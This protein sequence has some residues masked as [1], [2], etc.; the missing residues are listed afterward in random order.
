M[1]VNTYIKR[2]VKQINLKNWI[3]R[4]FERVIQALGNRAGGSTVWNVLG[5][6]IR[7]LVSQLHLI[8]SE[9]SIALPA[10]NDWLIYQL[11]TF[12]PSRKIPVLTTILGV[13]HTRHGSTHH[14]EMMEEFFTYKNFVEVE[15][16]DVVVDVGAYVGGFT[17]FAAS[18]A[19]HVIAIEPSSVLYD[20]LRYNTE[21]FDNVSIL[22]KA[23]WKGKERLELQCSLSPDENSIFQPDRG[24]SGVKIEVEA[25]TVSNLVKDSG[26]E[27]IDFLKLEAEGAEPEILEGA[28]AD[29]LVP[30]KIAVDVNPE[31]ED[32]AVDNVIINLLEEHDFTWKRKSEAR[33]WGD[34]YI[35]AKSPEEL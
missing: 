16:G 14:V 33:Y 12:R 24:A 10:G 4:Q 2:E 23:A 5:H 19:R 7:I 1:I 17:I 22:E 13:S 34:Q 18:K 6:P 20:A 3:I 35:F 8:L 32:R 30:R 25:D 26:F 21:R 9:G 11:P 29:S 15:N 27:R 31:R 28:L